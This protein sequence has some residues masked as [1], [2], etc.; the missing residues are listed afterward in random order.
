MHDS[1]ILG[2][3][4]RIAAI[5]QQSGIKHLIDRI[6]DPLKKKWNDSFLYHLLFLKKA[7]DQECRLLSSF[8]HIINRII[9]WLSKKLQAFFGLFSNSAITY[10]TRSTVNYLAN[11][12]HKSFF[13]KLF[14]RYMELKIPEGYSSVNKKAVLYTIGAWFLVS[15]LGAVLLPL[16][17][18]VLL[19]GGIVFA[20]LVFVYPVFGVFTVVVGSAFLPTMALVGMILLT[21]VSFV[22]RLIK[23]P[24]KPLK[25]DLLGIAIGV[26]FVVIVISS[27]FSYERTESLKVAAVVLVFMAFYVV[28]YNLIENKRQLKA[29]ISLFLLTGLGIA[30]IGIYQNFAGTSAGNVWIDQDMFSDIQGRVYSTFDNPNV[31]GEYLLLLIPLSFAWFVHMKKPLAKSITLMNTLFLCLCMIFTYSRGCWLGLIFAVVLFTAFYNKHYFV[32]F[33]IVG[34][35]AV[36]FLPD[37]I[38]NRFTS[39]GNLEDSSS[40]YRLFIYLGSIGLLKHF[41]F[42]GI[43][44]GTPAFNRIYPYYS[45]STILAPHSHNLYLQT[46]IEY[47][48]AG[49]VSFLAICCVFFQRAFH[50]VKEYGEN[51][52]KIIVVAM[53]AGM[54]GY[55]IQSVFDYTF[56]NYRMILIFYTYL[57]FSSLYRKFLLIE[58][59]Q[60]NAES[61]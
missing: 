11:L 24:K 22:A 5:Y 27:L 37:S 54:T 17:Y 1:L 41:W 47:G 28:L 4:L 8:V 56:Y 29:L 32:L 49:I 12:F 19:S 39:I 57:C 53:I 18:A 10:G 48:L 13:G 30:L 45:Y 43:G 6:F 31:F 14:Y 9:R 36:M 16:K 26:F 50:T 40:L 44:P 23:Q 58:K 2:F 46:F 60:T 55:L 33:G 25:I 42:S 15:L 21:I 52:E 3:F 20:A 7:S 38:I 61:I 51:K 35:V 34:V 59:E